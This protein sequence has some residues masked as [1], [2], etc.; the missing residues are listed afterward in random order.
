MHPESALHAGA[1]ALANHAF[2]L[3]FQF[4]GV[5]PTCR[6]NHLICQRHLFS[7]CISEETGCIAGGTT[8]RCCCGNS[9][10]SW[11]SSERL[12]TCEVTGFPLS[13]GPCRLLHPPDRLGCIAM[14]HVRRRKCASTPE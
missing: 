3:Y 8:L 9:H 13:G 4:Y 11:Y 14:L 1:A 5:H 6:G 2:D 7:L 12:P 10:R